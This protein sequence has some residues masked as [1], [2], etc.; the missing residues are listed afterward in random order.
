MDQ[1][2]I[3]AISRL[4]VHDVARYTPLADECVE[5]LSGMAGLLTY[6]WFLDETE[7]VSRF[8][9]CFDSS[10]SML[11]HMRRL[12][13]VYPRVYE[14]ATLEV[15]DVFGEPSDELRE[16]LGDFEGVRYWGTARGFERGWG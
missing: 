15:V 2:P 5:R 3:S 12:D 1:D 13:D 4:R 16:A 10:D 8:L 6:E 9:E 14:V 11:E 7:S